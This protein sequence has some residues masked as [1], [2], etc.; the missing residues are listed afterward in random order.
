MA[1]LFA[2]SL[3]QDLTQ[4]FT[5]ADDYDVKIEVGE[6]TEKETFKAHSVILRARSPYFKTALSSTWVKKVDDVVIFSKPNI[7]PRVFRKILRY[8]Y[9]GEFSLIEDN[10]QDNMM[11][12]D[13]DDLLTEDDNSLME[14]D[15]QDI[16]LDLLLAADELALVELVKYMEEYIITYERDWVQENLANIFTTAS[17]YESF[18]RLWKYFCGEILAQQPNTLFNSSYFLSLAKST[19]LEFIGRDDLDIEEVEIWENLIKWACDQ[20]PKIDRDVNQFTQSDLKELGN[21][22]KDFIPLIRF[23]NISKEGYLSKIQPYE[24]I[25][26]DDLKNE[27]KNF[28][29]SDNGSPPEGHLPP[30][31]P[32]LQTVP[33]SVII[34]N[35]QLILIG[36]WID[37]LDNDDS[38]FNL[39]NDAYDFYLLLRGSRDGMGIKPFHTLCLYKGPTLVV[40]KVKGTNQIIGGYNPDS[41]S[42]TGG[43]KAKD[44]FIFS[45]GKDK[46]FDNIILSRI[47]YDKIA[48][49]NSSNSLGFED[50]K[51]FNGKYHKSNFKKQ[52]MENPD[53]DFII[54]DYEVFRVVKCS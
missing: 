51:W 32:V 42:K 40:I 20:I 47:E 19:L 54:E 43:S 37:S 14:D 25:L 2:N 15:I 22:L 49:S 48:I 24:E 33:D 18:T 38:R 16:L 11:E 7:S 34:N 4:L 13:D 35:K 39:L 44:S 27:L 36:S 30:R 5:E 1:P 17:Q 26:P 23:F 41:W 31:V 52:I 53:D 3:F 29:E 45:L 28:F 10:V 12:E 21:R 50:L 9:T 6:G 46:S 8:I